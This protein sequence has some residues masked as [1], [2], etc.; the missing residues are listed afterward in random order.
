MNHLG[1]GIIGSGFNAR[2]HLQAFVGVRDAEVRGIWSPNEKNA[3][4]AA[5]LAHSLEVGEPQVYRSISDMVADP[6]IGAI[7]L[8][9]PNPKPEI[10]WSISRVVSVAAFCSPKTFSN[11]LSRLRRSLTYFGLRP[12]LVR[13]TRNSLIRPDTTQLC[14]HERR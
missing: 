4:E 8:C 9:G 1:I 13:D 5:A 2:F 7:W 3:A 10:H 6:G 12:L 11:L 14:A